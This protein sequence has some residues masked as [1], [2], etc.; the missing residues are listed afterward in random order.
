MRNRGFTLLEIVLAIGLSGAVIALLTTAIDL[1]LVRVEAGRNQVETAQLARTIL[2]QIAAEIRA[3]RLVTTGDSEEES[4]ESTDESALVLGIFGTPTELRIDRSAAPRWEW[5]AA[6]NAADAAETAVTDEPTPQN[7]PQTV[8]YVLGDGKELLPADL[9]GRGVSA[10]PMEQGYAG[11]YREQ[12]PTAAWLEQNAAVAGTSGEVST[13]ELFA[14][15]VVEIEFTY[16]DGEALLSEWD[17]SLEERLP[18]AIQIR[19]VLLKVP[20]VQ[21]TFNAIAGSDELR[22]KQENLVEYRSFVRLAPVTEPDEAEFPQAAS[23]T[24]EN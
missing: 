8:R 5:I 23:Q 21:E 24:Q 15:E 20:F 7:M 2:N 12:L 11:L 9:A 4:S 1:Y 3:A 10:Q 18:A 19:L 6:Q 14:P 16:F 13:A 22:R 17:S